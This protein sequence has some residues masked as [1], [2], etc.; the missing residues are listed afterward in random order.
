LH[1]IGFPLS[2]NNLKNEDNIQ[3]KIQRCLEGN[4]S[5]GDKCIR[6]RNEKREERKNYHRSSGTPTWLPKENINK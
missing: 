5:S 4:T 3:R 1:T 2:S 6:V